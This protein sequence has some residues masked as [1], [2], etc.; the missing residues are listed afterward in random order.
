MNTVIFRFS[1]E[2]GFFSNA[3]KVIAIVKLLCLYHCMKKFYFSPRS[4]SLE[5]R[6]LENPAVA[7]IEF[8]TANK[9]WL[10]LCIRK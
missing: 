1:L 5:P 10:I 8:L 9:A 3:Y 6:S 4:F 2:M 7:T